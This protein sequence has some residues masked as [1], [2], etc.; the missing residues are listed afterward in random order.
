MLIRRVPRATQLAVKGAQTA[1]IWRGY[2]TPDGRQGE[3][4]YPAL[5]L[6]SL[7][8]TKGAPQAHV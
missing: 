3:R 5:A 2:A 1:T 6:V 4:R 7:T 8:S